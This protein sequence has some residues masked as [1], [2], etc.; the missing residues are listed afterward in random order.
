[1]DDTALPIPAGESPLVPD[2]AVDEFDGAELSPHPLDPSLVPSAPVGDIQKDV[3]TQQNL[4]PIEKPQPD[5]IGRSD[6][7]TVPEVANPVNPG[8]KP[9]PFSRS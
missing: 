5:P 1:M 2:L 8:P 6:A 4:K 9:D 3:D 7:E